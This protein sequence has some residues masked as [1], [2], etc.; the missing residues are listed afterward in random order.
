[1]PHHSSAPRRIALALAALIAAVGAWFASRPSGDPQAGAAERKRLIARREKLFN[2][3]ARLEQDH[4]AGRVD[5][6]RYASRR[7]E[8]VTSLEAVYNAL[9]SHDPEAGPPDRAGVA[10]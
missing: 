10:A 2:E 1:M 9:D 3:L 8:L 4:R 7:E 6:R 5:A